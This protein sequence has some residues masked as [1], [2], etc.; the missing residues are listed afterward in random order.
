MARKNFCDPNM[1]LML[2][3]LLKPPNDW[4]LLPG[5]GLLNGQT[6]RPY[7]QLLV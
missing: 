7:N 1:A 6:A 4:W 5:I 2:R 3:L